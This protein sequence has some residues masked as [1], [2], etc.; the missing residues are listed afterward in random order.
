MG[1]GQL[2]GGMKQRIAIARAIIRDPKI[3][4]L[5]EATAAL[6]NESEEKVQAALDSLQEKQP[7]TTLVVAHRLLIVKKCNQ[8]AY[9]GNGGVIEI[10]S[11]DE[12]LK[13]DGEYSKLWIM[14]NA[15]VKLD[16]RRM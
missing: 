12:L 3:L 7:R 16:L 14:Q 5:D 9:L 1:G 8:I 13:K 10:G 15:E 6:D 4:V 2:S 11:H